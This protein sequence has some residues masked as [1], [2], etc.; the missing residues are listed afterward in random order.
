LARMKPLNVIKDFVRM[1]FA[2]RRER[3]ANR[4]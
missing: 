4:F 2:L 1:Y 3:R